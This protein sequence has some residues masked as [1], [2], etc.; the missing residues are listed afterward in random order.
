MRLNFNQEWEIGEPLDKGGFG[1]VRLASSGEIQAVAKFVPKVPGAEREMLF[2]ELG[3]ARNVIPIIDSGETEDSWV[4]I[5]PRAE[6]SLRGH[7]DAKG[8][9]LSVGEVRSVLIDIAAA[10]VDLDGIVVHR[11][12]KPENVLLHGGRWCLADFGISRY[13][14][15]STAEDTRKFSL[16]APYAAPERWRTEHATAAC[17]VYALGVMGY[18]MLS[19]ARPFAGPTQED[20][21]EQHL[22]DSPGPLLDGLDVAL[23]TVIEQCLI[24]A[25]GARPSV[26]AL[27]TRLEASA[28]APV[29]AGLSRLQEAGRAESNRRAEAER[30][31]SQQ[32]T[33][34]EQRAAL[35]A[36]AVES[37]G[38]ITTEVLTSITAVAPDATRLDRP[39]GTSYLKLGPAELG[40]FRADSVNEHPWG[41]QPMVAFDV[42]ACAAI[43]IAMPQDRNGYEG[44]SH[45]LW[46]C[47]A[48][49]TGE[50]GWYE[51]AF[52]I[53]PLM[54]QQTNRDPFARNPGQDAIQALA[55]M[56]GSVQV[57][58]PF[59]QITPGALGEFI[60]RWAGWLADAAE[61]KL[62]RP[63]QMPEAPTEGSWRSS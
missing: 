53:S 59:T 42:V 10:L 46:F 9:A 31:A 58:W 41:P 38:V 25:P 55:P 45:S 37:Y 19:G 13:A 23:A 48:Q 6:R 20:F 24:K 56:M 12:I 51:T 35:R 49:S 47:D 29:S 61:G 57:A 63:N 8:P 11:D 17:D 27:L 62:H 34:A 26:S 18:E 3:T 54:A 14:E 40:L 1:L 28:A 4:M 15:A 21:R 30:R 36:A 33:L 60:D 50:Y 22:H 5:M 32:A 44:R 7:I 43:G 2:V 39:D 52:M 16:S